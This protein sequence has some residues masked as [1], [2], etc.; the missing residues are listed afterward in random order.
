VRDVAR[1]PQSATAERQDHR[2]AEDQTPHA[3]SQAQGPIDSRDA[4]PADGDAVPA[5]GDA[6]PADGDAV[7]ALADQ[8]RDGVET[9]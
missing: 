5:D 2:G 1:R 9:N 4:V 7:P 6:V 3:R 8:R